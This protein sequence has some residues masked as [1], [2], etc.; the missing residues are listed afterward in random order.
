M[1][2]DESS[3]DMFNRL[4]KMVNKVKDLGS[5]KWTDH[6]LIEQLMRTYTPMNYNVIALIHQDPTYKKMISDDVLRSIIMWCP[7]P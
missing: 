3:Q 7:R 2:D 5:K 1:F 6:M 4:K